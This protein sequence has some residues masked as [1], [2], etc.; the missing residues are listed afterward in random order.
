MSR[1]IGLGLH[2]EYFSLVSADEKQIDAIAILELSRPFDLKSLRDGNW[3]LQ[4]YVETLTA[5]LEKIGHSENQVGVALNS[6]MVHIKKVPIA[7]GLEEEL[8]RDQLQ[9]EAEQLLISPAEQYSLAYERLPFSAPAGNP[10]YL[11]VLVRKKIIETVGRIV[12]EA[13]LRISGI[14]V[15]YFALIRVLSQCYDLDPKGVHVV[16][17]LHREWIGLVFIRKQD[18]FLSHKIYLQSPFEDPT[19]PVKTVLKDLRRIIFGHGLGKS[20]E[21]INHF[22]VLDHISRKDFIKMFSESVEGTVEPIQPFQKMIVADEV[23]QSEEVAVFPERF[24][25]SIGA[26]LKMN[27]SIVKNNSGEIDRR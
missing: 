7:M 5:L 26:V 13:G 10:I 12:S 3:A 25:T 18:Y 9:W 8:I 19:E 21:D 4:Y 22:F 17:E 20:I 6:N 23:S 15:D 14:D 2:P 24:T 27:P 16:V 11:Q 1:F